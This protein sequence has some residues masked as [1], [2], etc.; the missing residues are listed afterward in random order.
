MKLIIHWNKFQRMWTMHTYKSCKLA[1]NILVIGKWKTEVKPNR[2]SNPRGWVVTE[3]HN[4]IVDPDPSLLG[5]FEKVSRLIY[6]KSNVHF[7]INEGEYLWFNEEGCFVVQ[8][9]S[10][11]RPAVGE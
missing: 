4:V 1:K 7:N 6:D 11:L 9:V 5:Q 10:Q 2:K 8:P 3:H